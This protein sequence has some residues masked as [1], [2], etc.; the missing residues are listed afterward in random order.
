MHLIYTSLHFFLYHDAVAMPQ[1]IGILETFDEKCTQ[2][3]FGDHSSRWR[4]KCDSVLGPW[5]RWRK[6]ICEISQEI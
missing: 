3:V 6:K 4:I 2:V 1:I 5:C